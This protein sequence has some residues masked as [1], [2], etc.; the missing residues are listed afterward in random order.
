MDED[1][2]PELLAH[3]PLEDP[4]AEPDILVAELRSY[5]DPWLPGVRTL[6]SAL[7]PSAELSSLGGRLIAFNYEVESTGR[8]MPGPGVAGTVHPRFWISAV[9]DGRRIDC[10]PLILGWESHNRT[11]MVLDPGFAATYG[12]IPR[13]DA[14][15]AVRWDN[16]AEPEFDVA[17]VSAPSLY[18]DLRQS[19]GRATIARDYLQDY[20]SLRGMELIQVYYES[21]RG[22][23]DAAIDA[24]L[25]EREQ[26]TV[27]LA[28]REVDIR[29]RHEG[30]FFAQVW[31]A[32]HIA[33]PGALPVTE[34]PLE[35]QG[36][37]WPGIDIPVTT[38]VAQRQ[39][40]WDNVYVR[41]A[42]LGAYE[43]RAGFRVHPE[44][45]SVGYGNQWSVGPATRVGRDVIRLEVRKLYEGT[46]PRVIQHW[47]DFAIAPTP[48]LLAPEARLARNVGVRARELAYGLADIGI[49]LCG[50]AAMIRM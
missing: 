15:G 36:L 48:E 16:P 8:P 50:I 18:V 1:W 43:G 35:T 34:N 27:K 4:W 33:G 25:D 22:P 49:A 21:R 38:A 23:Q 39:R 11:A 20:L 28:T 12:L 9:D 30:G 26:L 32:R 3:I 29:R 47:H 10:E 46:R 19:G 24:L 6:W 45:G 41:D 42:V 2:W 44:T 37:V 7:I 40:P 13:A 5:D 14:D 31:G 17:V